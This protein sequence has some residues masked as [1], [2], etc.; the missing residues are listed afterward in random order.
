MRLS[1]AHV[2][3]TKLGEGYGSVSIPYSRLGSVKNA[4]S[5]AKTIPSFDIKTNAVDAM[6][7]LES[8]DSSL[9]AVTSKGRLS[10]IVTLQNLQAF[11]SLHVLNKKTA[12]RQA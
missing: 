7:M 9:A 1:R 4:A 8:S 2:M 12:A 3:I 6:T 5:I 10:G 11:L